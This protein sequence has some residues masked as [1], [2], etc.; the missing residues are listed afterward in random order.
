[1]GGAPRLPRHRSTNLHG[2]WAPARRRSAQ[3]RSGS[4]QPFASQSSLPICFAH[5]ANADIVILDRQDRVAWRGVE[6]ASHAPPPR[7]KHTLTPLSGG[8]L[9]MFGGARCCPC[10]GRPPAGQRLLGAVRRLAEPLRSSYALPYSARPLH[11]PC[12]WS[13]LARMGLRAS[14]AQTHPNHPVFCLQAPTGKARWGTRG[15]LIWSTSC[16]SSQ[17]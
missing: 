4:F 16:S 2:A 6:L 8:R 11:A 7:E 12:S 17:I 15:G 14:P 10:R 13:L 5:A 9:L 3:P 1:M